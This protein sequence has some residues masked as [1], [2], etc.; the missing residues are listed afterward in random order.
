MKWTK[1]ILKIH[2]YGGLVCFWYLII[3]AISSLDFHHHFN[4]MENKLSA[5]VREQIPL[6]LPANLNDSDL[7]IQIQN[8]REV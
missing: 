1:W 7:A 8:M 6:I 4:F 5:E 2:L 3:L